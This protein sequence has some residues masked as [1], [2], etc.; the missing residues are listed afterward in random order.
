M[1]NIIYTAKLISAKEKRLHRREITYFAHEKADNNHQLLD[2]APEGGHR[3][4]LRGFAQR[5]L[6]FLVSVAVLELKCRNA[7]LQYTTRMRRTKT[8]EEMSRVNE[9]IPFSVNDIYLAQKLVRF[10]LISHNE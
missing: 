7:T 4:M 9:A 2:R 8:I 1:T 5:G 6:E 10:I 3:R